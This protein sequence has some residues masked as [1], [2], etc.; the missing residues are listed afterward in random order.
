MLQYFLGVVP[1]AEET[2]TSRCCEE[3]GSWCVHFDWELGEFFF[4]MFFGIYSTVQEVELYCTYSLLE[5]CTCFEKHPSESEHHARCAQNRQAAAVVWNG[6][7]V[8]S[9]EAT[10][11]GQSD[12]EQASYPKEVYF[13]GCVCL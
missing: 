5:L 12:L 2:K 1:K 7:G 4:R 3:K 13:H 8:G 6:H 10:A 9:R 11:T